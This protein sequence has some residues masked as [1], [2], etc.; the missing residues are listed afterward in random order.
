MRCLLSGKTVVFA[1]CLTLIMSTATFA[2]TGDG[3]LVGYVR[4]ASGAIL[5][6]IT[7]TATS[8]GLIGERQVFSDESG[9]FRIINLPVGFYTL[10]AEL[11]GF[12]T[13]RQEAINVRAGVRSP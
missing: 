12:S 9:Y 11:P 3:G 2:Q 13:F 8:P 6:G 10:I 4:D 1:I 5:P 7:L